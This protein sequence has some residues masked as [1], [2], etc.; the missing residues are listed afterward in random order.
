MSA[1]HS[2]TRRCVH[3]DPLPFHQLVFDECEVQQVRQAASVWRRHGGNLAPPDAKQNVSSS[4]Q[5]VCDQQPDSQDG[6]RDNNNLADHLDLET[7][8]YFTR[9]SNRQGSLCCATELR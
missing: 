6:E 5:V 4:Y 8:I 3:D 7:F 2:G 9:S 1:D